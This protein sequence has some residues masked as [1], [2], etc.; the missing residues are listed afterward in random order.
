MT[1]E[2]LSKTERII[3]TLGEEIVTG[4]YLPGA[5]L[6]SEADLCE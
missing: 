6:P 2:S 5:P 3:L 1:Q 4:K